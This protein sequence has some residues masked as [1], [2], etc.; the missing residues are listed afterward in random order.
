MRP[1]FA[2]IILIIIIAG[3]VILGIRVFGTPSPSRTN[4]VV[5]YEDEYDDDEDEEEEEEED[6]DQRVK[7]TRR[8]R[9]AQIV[10]IVIILVGAIIIL[11]T[12]SMVKWLVWA[13]IGAFIIMAIG[14]LTILIARRSRQ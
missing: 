14:I 2:E 7:Q 8:S 12:L 6:Y 13:P 5:R 1:G 11:S 3:I 10:G 4:K 9:L